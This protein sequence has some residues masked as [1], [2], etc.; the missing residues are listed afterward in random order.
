MPQD[1]Y[2]ADK[3]IAE[4]IAI[5]EE[6]S[7]IDKEKMF[8]CARIAR[9][10]EGVLRHPNGYDAMVGER[11]VSLSGGQIQRLA[12]ARALYKGAEILVFDEATSA[13][14]RATEASIIRE[15]GELGEGI[16]T[17]TIAH[18]LETLNGCDQIIE[19]SEGKVKKTG[20]F[21]EVLGRLPQQ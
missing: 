6:R 9:I 10:H 14:D 17:I 4:N 2:L 20:S 12:I 1:I 7:C 8:Y 11:G 16:T 13:L 18:R 5:N 15:L 21:H 19:L 3:T